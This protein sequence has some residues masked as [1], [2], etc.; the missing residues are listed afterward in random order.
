MDETNS[1]Q[2][3]INLAVIQWETRIAEI[4]EFTLTPDWTDHTF[5]QAIDEANEAA[6]D[7]DINHK[8]WALFRSRVSW[9]WVVEA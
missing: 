1:Q 4:T 2:V 6:R 5:L 3:L 7:F 8:S 9:F